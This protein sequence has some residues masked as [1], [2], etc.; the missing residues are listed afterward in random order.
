M[1]DFTTSSAATSTHIR[2][3]SSACSPT[4]VSFSVWSGIISCTLASF[5]TS[6]VYGTS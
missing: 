5:R 6:L 1:D 4:Y 3:L 2:A